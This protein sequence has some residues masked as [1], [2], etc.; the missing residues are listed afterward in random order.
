[1]QKSVKTWKGKTKG[2]QIREEEL[3]IKGK[4]TNFTTKPLQNCSRSQGKL[5]VILHILKGLIW[6]AIRN[7]MQVTKGL[8][9]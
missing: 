5:N 9:S 1:M 8:I 6:G 2:N 4:M 7:E 3:R